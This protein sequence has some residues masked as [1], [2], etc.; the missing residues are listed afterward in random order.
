MPHHSFRSPYELREAVKRY[1][2]KAV[3]E[4]SSQRFKQEPAYT[5]ALAAK[6][7]GVAYDGKHGKVTFQATVFDDRG[8]NAAEDRLGADFAITAEISDGRDQVRKA[9]IFQAKR[10]FIADLSASE[11][12]RLFGQIRTM[13]QHTRSPKVLELGDERRRRPRVISGTRV[14]ERGRYVP[15]ELPEYF[16]GRVLTTFDG[17]TRPDFIA[18]VQ[19]SSFPTIHMLADID[20]S[21]ERKSV[22]EPDYEAS[23]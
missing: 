5:A 4:L 3:E 13:R 17:D 6:L 9:I 22:P 23:K 19:Y 12:D 1:V 16:T 8:R 7:D 18:S 15:Q 10:G 2:R 20:Q 14:V 21:G 11:T